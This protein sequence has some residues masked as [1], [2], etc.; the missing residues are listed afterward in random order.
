MEKA[1]RVK[2]VPAAPV[3]IPAKVTEQQY[4]EA[5]TAI[6]LADT[7]NSLEQLKTIYK[8]YA[9]LKEIKVN[10]TTLLDVIN[11]KRE[12]LRERQTKEI[13]SI[14][15]IYRQCSSERFGY[16]RCCKRT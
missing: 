12:S 7:A 2:E 16:P 5:E 11:R 14:C 1:D 13:C 8:E 6:A 4:T 3:V 15:R 9:S 10:G